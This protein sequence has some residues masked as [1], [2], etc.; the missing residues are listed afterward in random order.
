MVGLAFSDGATPPFNALDADIGAEAIPFLSDISVNSI[1]EKHANVF[2]M[3]PSQ[4]DERIPVLAAIHQSDGTS[5]G[6]RSSASRITLFS[7]SL[8]D[9]LKKLGD[10]AASLPTI[11]WPAEQQARSGRDRRE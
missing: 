6:R 11:G 9:G 2:T 3:R 5:S 10:G 7:S 8:G 1:F 4:D